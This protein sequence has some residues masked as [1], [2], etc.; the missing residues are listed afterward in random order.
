[1][2]ATSGLLPLISSNASVSPSWSVS[3]LLPGL[4]AEVDGVV[5]RR[6]RPPACQVRTAAAAPAA[7]SRS[8]RPRAGPGVP[9]HRRHVV[10]VGAV[11]RRGPGMRRMG[12]GPRPHVEPVVGD[13]VRR[14]GVDVGSLRSPHTFWRT[15][16]RDVDL[17]EPAG[18]LAVGVVRPG[19]A[20][21]L[22]QRDRGPRRRLVRGEPGSTRRLVDLAD[23]QF[24]VTSP[25]CLRPGNRASVAARAVTGISS[26]GPRPWGPVA[27]VHGVPARSRPRNDVHGSRRGRR[28]RRRRCWDWATGR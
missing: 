3:R 26:V 14:A 7:G 16:G 13:V 18:V 10:E 1:M 22:R 27:S 15:L 6:R 20:T 8:P 28:H 21:G 12:R 4:H 9:G 2:S 24:H 5:R 11:V 17:P 19:L 25:E 23:S